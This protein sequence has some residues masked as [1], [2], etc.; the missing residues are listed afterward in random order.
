MTFADIE[1]RG[2]PG[3]PLKVKGVSRDRFMRSREAGSIY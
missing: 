1:V 3:S 2:R